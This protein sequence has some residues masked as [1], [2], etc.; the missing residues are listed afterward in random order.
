MARLVSIVLVAL[1]AS[2]GCGMDLALDAKCAE[3]LWTDCSE[4][5]DGWWYIDGLNLAG[6]QW[7]CG[8]PPPH[9]CDS[10]TCGADDIEL[11]CPDG[12]VLKLDPDALL[13]DVVSPDGACHD[14]HKVTSIRYAS[15]DALNR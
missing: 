9:G 12:L 5:C 10:A 1:A 2:S 15:R 8:R 14:M 11:L 4:P 7:P 13:V 6:G 3:D